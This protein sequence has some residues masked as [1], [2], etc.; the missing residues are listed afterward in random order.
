[1]AIR[2][3]KPIKISMGSR[4]AHRYNAADLN[5]QLGRLVQ[6][7]QGLAAHMGSQSAEILREALEPTFEKSKVYCPKDTHALVNSGFLEVQQTRNGAQAAMGY[8]RGGSPHY[9][10]YVH[11]I[12]RFHKEPTRWKWLQQALQEDADDIR[13]RI[14]NGCTR[15]SNIRA[16][17]SLGRSSARGA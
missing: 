3:F 17:M 10:V 11:E 2:G 4:A 12:P 7:F 15:A 8:A 9:A 1:M 6:N 5:R 14:I 16:V 13:T